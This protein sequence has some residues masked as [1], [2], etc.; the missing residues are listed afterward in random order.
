MVLVV[1]QQMQVIFILKRVVAVGKSFSK[2]GILIGGPPLSLFDMLLT[3]RRGS[4]YASNDKKG[5]K[6]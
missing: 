4:K 5:F 6:S 2:L 3:T 1:L